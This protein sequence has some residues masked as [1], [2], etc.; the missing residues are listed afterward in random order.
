MPRSEGLGFD[1]GGPAHDAVRLVSLLDGVEA[2]TLCGVVRCVAD[3]PLLWGVLIQCN[4]R[5]GLGPT[6][7]LTPGSGSFGSHWLGMGGRG[8]K[9][10]SRVH[11]CS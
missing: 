9:I 2:S 8:T 11:E 4:N 3:R 7:L 1:P 5:M 10:S 6:G